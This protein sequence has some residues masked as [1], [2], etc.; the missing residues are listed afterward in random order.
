[1]FKGSGPVFRPY[2]FHFRRVGLILA[3]LKIGFITIKVDLI[4]NGLKYGL[5]RGL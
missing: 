3:G 1:M 2:L 5:K 4:L